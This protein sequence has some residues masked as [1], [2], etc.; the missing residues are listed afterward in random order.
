MDSLFSHKVKNALVFLALAGVASFAV[1]VP[2]AAKAG[3]FSFADIFFES[4]EAAGPTYTSAT[5]TVL[6]PAKNID[7]NP[8]I[9]GGDIAIVAGGALLPQEGP[10]GTVADIS[11]RPEAT[12]ISIHVVRE[13]DTLSQIAE[14][15]GVK[16][17]TIIWANDIKGRHIQPGQELVILP[18]TG[19]RHTVAQ[20]E[21]LASVVKKYQGDLAETAS[22]NELSPDAPLAV[23]SVVIIPDGVVAPPPAAARTSGTAGSSASLRGA[24]GPAVAGY[25]GWPVSG[26][27]VTQGLHG[28]NGVDIGAPYGTSVLASADGTVI[29]ARSGGY[30]GG[31][32]SYV[33]I[34]HNNGTQTLYAHLSAVVTSAGTTVGRGEMVGKVGSTGKSTGNHL[35]FEV[36][37]AANPFAR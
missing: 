28:F 20:G 12:Q 2:L 15:Y 24:G 32:G 19:V 30:N 31:Y 36:R 16:I 1:F 3:L 33:V 14:L 26:G 18:I 21:T 13:G 5:M 8:N 29:I 23:G 22:Y 7:P 27:V 17:N 25:Y 35:H 10:S 9:G 34:Q 37:G 6:S 11:H 4:A